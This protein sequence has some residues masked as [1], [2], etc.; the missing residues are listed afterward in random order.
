MAPGTGSGKTECFV[1]P[2]LAHCLAEHDV[3]GI[4]AIL[5]CPMNALGT[6]RAR[7]PVQ[8]YLHRS[9]VTLSDTCVWQLSPHT[10]ASAN[11]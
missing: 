2:I 3:S 10:F 6:P 8:G 7:Y 5:V 11:P 9:H 4:K 1:Q